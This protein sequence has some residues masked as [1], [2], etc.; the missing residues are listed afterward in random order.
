LFVEAT[1]PAVLLLAHSLFDSY[2]KMREELSEL[3][4]KLG[5]PPT[6]AAI[7]E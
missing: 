7:G 3:R 4:A 2:V 5:G 1:I 6:H